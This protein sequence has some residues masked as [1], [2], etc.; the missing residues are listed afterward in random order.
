MRYHDPVRIQAYCR[1]CEKYGKYW[2]C[3]PFAEQPL[4][5]FPAWT[6]AI[7]VTRKSPVHTGATPDE[8]LQLFL[9][10]RQI[11]NDMLKQWEQPGTVSVGA[12]HCS[13]CSA[14]TRS[15]GVKC[16]APERIQYSLEGLGFD[17][18]GL[19]EGLAGQSLHW[20]ASG[21]PDYLVT[22]GALLCP[23][24]DLAAELAHQYSK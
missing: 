13:G 4:P 19:I 21:I 8:L 2:A 9:A 1:S 16:C 18:T 6:H 12:G 14:C 15:K 24:L 7:L 22:V 17:V 23:S 5:N 10:S 20:P 3:P 11:L